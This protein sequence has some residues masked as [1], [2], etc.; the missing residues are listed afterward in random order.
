MIMT[1]EQFTALRE[2]MRIALAPIAAK[3][4]CEVSIG[5][6][7]Y[8]DITTNVAV[9]LR[10]KAKDKSADQMV[11][12]KYAVQYGFAPTDFGFC[13]GY[14]GKNYTFTSFKPTARK[15]TCLCACS[16]GK[17]YGFEAAAIKEFMR[18]A[19]R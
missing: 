17:T 11:F 8:D 16:D 13:F 12:E 6:I 19:G 14:E 15:Y 7:K 4:G 2:E 1:K 9:S 3:Y 18:R 5:N 10:S